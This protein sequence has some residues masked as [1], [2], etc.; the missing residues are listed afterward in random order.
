MLMH[1]KLSAESS[2]AD[3]LLCL[4]AL[5]GFAFLDAP[6]STSAS[7][8][9]LGVCALAAPSGEAGPHLRLDGPHRAW[10]HRDHLREGEED[11]TLPRL[12]DCGIKKFLFMPPEREPELTRASVAYQRHCPHETIGEPLGEPSRLTRAHDAM[13]SGDV[14]PARCRIPAGAFVYL[15]DRESYNCLFK[16]AH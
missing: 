2:S 5:G 1:T 9:V 16:V 8:R 4:L 7:A 3:P 11:V 10:L 13:K 14:A 6:P 15:Y 12:V